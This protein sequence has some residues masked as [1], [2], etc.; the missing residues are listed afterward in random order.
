MGSILSGAVGGY[1]ASLLSEADDKKEEDDIKT[2]ALHKHEIGAY[3]RRNGFYN[4]IDQ[5]SFGGITLDAEEYF[6]LKI[7]PKNDF[8]VYV[9]DLKFSKNSSLDPSDY[10]FW[11]DGKKV[12][13]SYYE[14]N[15][16]IPK[17]VSDYVK[18]R[19]ENSIGGSIDMEYLAYL[20]GDKK[21]EVGKIYNILEET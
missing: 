7:T 19:V 15:P 21:E 9:L 16:T 10:T 20:R 12:K 3:L 6:E 1:I 5:T 2:N 14:Y 17:Q 18:M 4:S 11:I 13:S 8:V